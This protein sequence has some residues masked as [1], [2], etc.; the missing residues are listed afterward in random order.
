METVSS[1]KGGTSFDSETILRSGS[2]IVSSVAT[3]LSISV[4]SFFLILQQE[5][6]FLPLRKVLFLL[7]F[8]HLLMQRQFSFSESTVSG[9]SFVV[10]GLSVVVS[11]SSFSESAAS[12]GWWFHPERT[13][14]SFSGFMLC[15]FLQ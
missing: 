1:V 9:D 4:S 5:V 2:D 10:S 3:L 8:Q 14:F 13:A 7:Y 12:A 11:V 6:Y 15:F